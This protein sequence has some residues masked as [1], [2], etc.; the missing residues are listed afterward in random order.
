M[1]HRYNKYSF[2]FDLQFHICK[3]TWIRKRGGQPTDL[4]YQTRHTSFQ[5][6][7]NSTQTDSSDYRPGIEQSIILSI[8]SRF[9]YKDSYIVKQITNVKMR[10]N[11]KQILI[12]RCND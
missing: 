12:K 4:T 5:Q 1:I 2:D 11:N 10:F 3:V 7:R 9:F 6:Y 8:A